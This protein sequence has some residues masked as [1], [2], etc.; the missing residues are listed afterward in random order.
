MALDALSWAIAVREHSL[1]SDG[2]NALVHDAQGISMGDVG[3]GTTKCSGEK[4]RLR[5]HEHLSV[6]LVLKAFRRYLHVSRV[7]GGSCPRMQVR[8]KAECMS[9]ALQEI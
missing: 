8:M 3:R 6:N 5:I 1:L 7:K 9:A 4:W 2:N